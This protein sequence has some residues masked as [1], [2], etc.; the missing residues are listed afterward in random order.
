[1]QAYMLCP[2]YCIDCPPTQCSMS[3]HS[4]MQCMPTLH[5]ISL[6]FTTALTSLPLLQATISYGLKPNEAFLLH[7]GFVDTSYKSDFYSADLLEH[8]QQQYGVSEDRVEGLAQNQQVYKSVE[9][10]SVM[11][12]L[13]K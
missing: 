5:G 2:V 11:A 7:Y 4:T 3:C 13:S 12:D 1:M 6:H 10:V 9:S 8:V